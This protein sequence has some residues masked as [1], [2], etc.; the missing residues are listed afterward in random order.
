[1]EKIITDQTGIK[2]QPPWISSQVGIK[3]SHTQPDSHPNQLILKWSGR[4]QKYV[5]HSNPNIW[6]WLH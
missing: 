6:V 2:T 5:V 3:S 4:T 1:M